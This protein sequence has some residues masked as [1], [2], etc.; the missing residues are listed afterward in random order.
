MEISWDEYFLLQNLTRIPA[1]EVFSGT[2]FVWFLQSCKLIRPVTPADLEGLSPDARV[3]LRIRS[4]G[5]TF[6]PNEDGTVTYSFSGRAV[7]A[8]IP[9]GGPRDAGKSRRPGR[10]SRET[11]VKIKQH[12]AELNDEYFTPPV[13]TPDSRF[14]MTYNTFLRGWKPFMDALRLY[15]LTVQHFDETPW[16]AS[17]ASLDMMIKTKD[18][19]VDPAYA[20]CLFDEI[21]QKRAG[22]LDALYIF[23]RYALVQGFIVARE[24]QTNTTDI[25]FLHI[26]MFTTARLPGVPLGN[27]LFC[28]TLYLAK[29]LSKYG[30]RLETI[31]KNQDGTTTKAFQFY[32]RFG[33]KSV[34]QEDEMEVME[35]EFRNLSYADLDKLLTDKS[36]SKA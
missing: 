13:Y 4:P 18:Q 34:D 17:A 5:L 16:S 15:G 3:E 31:D 6:T 11:I 21:D 28:G 36:F 7:R 29:Q 14:F 33:F 9:V 26:L 32:R 10:L 25:P 24:R 20:K 27:L 12:W 19:W 23:D 8:L 2:A 35:L 1:G 30:V 22:D